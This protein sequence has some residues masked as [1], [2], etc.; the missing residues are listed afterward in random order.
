MKVTE[1]LRV[2]GLVIVIVVLLVWWVL[3]SIG[4]VGFWWEQ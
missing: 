1:V 4:A 3:Y 2:V